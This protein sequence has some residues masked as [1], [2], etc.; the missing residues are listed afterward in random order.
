[1]QATNKS[2]ATQVY[3]GAV[4][5][6]RI[7]AKGTLKY[8][9]KPLAIFGYH[10]FIEGIRAVQKDGLTKELEKITN[11]SYEETIK[12]ME[13]CQQ[14]GVRVVATER[15]LEKENSEFSK[16]KSLYQQK[17]I[18]KYARRIKHLSNFKA[19]HPK[20]AKI[21]QMESAIKRNVSKQKEEQIKHKNKHYNVYF[22]K[23]KRDYMSARI[24][25]VIELRTGISQ[26]LFD[27]T[28]GKAIEN[29]QKE[30][31]VKLN[32]QQLE[33][34]SKEYKLHEFGSVDLG[35]CRKV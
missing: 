1:M 34:F 10:Y 31:K 23:S 12:V 21:L 24:A 14:D 35:R 15:T 2:D 33:E 17:K 7:G 28:T 18:T 4:K 29:L 20:V 22:N 25:D 19:D 3:E 26:K 13:K 16:K 32:S 11:L 27:E 5:S 6:S 9:L 30:G 8:I